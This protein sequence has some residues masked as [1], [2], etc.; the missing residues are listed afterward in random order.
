MFELRRIISNT[1]ISLIGQAISWLSTILLS[2]AYGHFLG[3]SKFGELYFAITFVAIIGVV[4][5]S[6]YGNQTIRDVVQEPTLA[7]RYFSNILLI[8]ISTWLITYSIILLI[9]WLMGYALEMRILIAISGF[10]LLCNAVVNT[11]VSMHYAFKR[12]IFPVVGDI[13]EKGLTSLLGVL[14]LSSGAG[15][16]VMAMVL[17]ACSLVNGIWQA[18]WYFRL[19]GT[20]FTIDLKLIGEMVRT[21]IPFLI[22]GVLGVAYVSIDAILLSQM[23]NS[24]VVGWYGAAT[25]ITYAM[26][27]LPSIVIMNIMYPVLSKL[28]TTADADVKLAI[29]KSINFLLFA[30]FLLPLC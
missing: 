28:S 19:V 15:V 21:N 6:G 9:S 29:E 25:R 26:G 30:V 23:T 12:A 8:K 16:Q 20:S 27:F 14:L 1:V 5:D 3:A 24:A 13:L 2:F 7:A 22:S 11:F 4:V 10:D 17:G 18:I